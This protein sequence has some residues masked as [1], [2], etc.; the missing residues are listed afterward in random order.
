VIRA[1]KDLLRASGTFGRPVLE[2]KFFCRQ[3]KL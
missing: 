1:L 2:A 3:C